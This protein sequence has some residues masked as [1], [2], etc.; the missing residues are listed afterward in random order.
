MAE[1]GHTVYSKDVLVRLTTNVIQIPSLETGPSEDRYM[2]LKVVQTTGFHYRM[3]TSL[4]AHEVDVYGCF[5]DL[6]AERMRCIS[7]AS[8]K[9]RL[10]IP[11]SGNWKIK[12]REFKSPPSENR[13]E[14]L[15][16]DQKLA[17]WPKLKGVVVHA[18][19]SATGFL[20]AEYRQTEATEAVLG[21]SQY[22]IQV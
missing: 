18:H 14:W 1:V 3:L 20:Y 5:D 2:F 12:Y 4:R 13:P 9:Q 7:F 6:N 8:A 19:A 11:D 16:M 10:P 21:V 17:K 22:C 15:T